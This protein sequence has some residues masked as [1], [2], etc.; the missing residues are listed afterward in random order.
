[1]LLWIFD[2]EAQ[3]HIMMR[4]LWFWGSLNTV[5][6]PGGGRGCGD[7]SVSFQVIL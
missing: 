4:G 3:G 7:L 5:T 2:T 6:K 1:M